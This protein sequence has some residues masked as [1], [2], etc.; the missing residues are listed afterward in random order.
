MLTGNAAVEIN[1]SGA[2]SRGHSK[3]PRQAKAARGNLLAVMEFEL[4]TERVNGF[5]IEADKLR[6][7]Y[8]CN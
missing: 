3:R 4:M 7:K 2:T 5:R 6:L 8:L 1:T